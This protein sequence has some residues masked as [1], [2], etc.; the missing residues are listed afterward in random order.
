MVSR[1]AFASSAP[2]A[3]SRSRQANRDACRWPVTAQPQAGVQNIDDVVAPQ[4]KWSEQQG[5]KKMSGKSAKCARKLSC[6]LFVQLLLN[7]A[8][9]WLE[10][11][12]AVTLLDSRC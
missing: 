11:I 1:Q 8:P 6:K 10:F 4:S 2:A 7:T 3:G 12:P 9:A 5:G